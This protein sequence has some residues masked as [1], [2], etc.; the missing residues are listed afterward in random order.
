VGDRRSWLDRGAAAS[1][2]IAQELAKKTV[3]RGGTRDDAARMLD[4]LGLDV[5][6]LTLPLALEAGAMVTVTRPK[7]LSEGD[8]ACLAL[9]AALGVPAVTADRPWADVADRLGVQV[10]LIR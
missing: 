1:A 2:L 3:E 6:D 9:A 10:E 7:R 5:R 8:R 4:D